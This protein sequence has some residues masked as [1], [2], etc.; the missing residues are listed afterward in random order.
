[1]SIAI[2]L[3]VLAFTDCL[4]CGFR[5]AA[6]RNG[7]LGKRAYYTRAVARAA[8]WGALLVASH[9]ALVVALGGWDLFL[10]AGRVLVWV[11]ATFASAIFLA[12]GFYFAPIGDFRVMTNVIVFGPLT[13]ARRGVIAGAMALAVWRVPDS[14]VALVA[15]TA[16]ISMLAFEPLLGRRYAHEWRRLVKHD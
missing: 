5:M 6:G 16:T 1:M 13:L 12:F 9:V 4:L 3:A 8:G 11:Y 2:A 10:E 7:M 14:R 15:V